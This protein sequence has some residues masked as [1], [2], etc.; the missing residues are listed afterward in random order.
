MMVT[1]VEPLFHDDGKTPWLAVG[2]PFAGC[3]HKFQVVWKAEGLVSFRRMNMELLRMIKEHV[4]VEH[5]KGKGPQ[6][7][8][9]L[10]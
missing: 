2:C 8:D 7:N 4:F 1:K 5:K 9:P 3:K 10:A 6:I